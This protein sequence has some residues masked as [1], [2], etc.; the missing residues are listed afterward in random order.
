MNPKPIPSQ[1]PTGKKPSEDCDNRSKVHN[2]LSPILNLLILIISNT[3]NFPRTPHFD[4]IAQ[5]KP[6]IEISTS[7]STS[8][9]NLSPPSPPIGRIDQLSGRPLDPQR[10]AERQCRLLSAPSALYSLIVS[11][12]ILKLDLVSLSLL[13]ITVDRSTQPLDSRSEVFLFSSSQVR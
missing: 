13:P 10:H 1:A 2:S 12:P 8:H 3:F 6:S 5:P 7:R 4:P 9:T 11:L